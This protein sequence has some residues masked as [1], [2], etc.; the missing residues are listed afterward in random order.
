MTDKGIEIEYV[1]VGGYSDKNVKDY[2]YFI[3]NNED[4]DGVIY[5]VHRSTLNSKPYYFTVPVPDKEGK[6]IT[7]ISE[8]EYNMLQVLLLSVC[9]K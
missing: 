8:P 5:N 7:C 4:K 3:K 2:Q 6:Q 1:L 9:P